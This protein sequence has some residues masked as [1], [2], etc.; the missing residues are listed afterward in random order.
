MS[1]QKYIH[2]RK[3]KKSL[4]L[5]KATSVTDAAF[6]LGYEN[7]SYFIQLFKREFGMTPKQYQLNKY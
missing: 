5:L 2:L 4:E 6:S 7:P 1:P 3:L